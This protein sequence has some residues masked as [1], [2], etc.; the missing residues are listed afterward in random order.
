MNTNKDNDK[1]QE[2]A[3]PGNPR[4]RV[5]FKGF[6]VEYDCTKPTAKWLVSES[7]GHQPYAE[8][9]GVGYSQTVAL[10]YDEQMA[11]RICDLLNDK[12]GYVQ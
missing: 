3:T 7:H 11:N 9:A 8:Q 12:R 2:S 6:Y 5:P 4:K 10:C 1:G